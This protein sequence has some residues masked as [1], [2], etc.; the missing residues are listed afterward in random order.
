MKIEDLS[1]ATILKA[2]ILTLLLIMIITVIVV[3]AIKYPQ[4]GVQ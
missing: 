2:V 4:L 3:I 1:E